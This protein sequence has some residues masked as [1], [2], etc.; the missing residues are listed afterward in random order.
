MAYQ[1]E[2]AGWVKTGEEHLHQAAII[3][4]GITTKLWLAASKKYDND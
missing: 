4:A 1:K 3:P 2:P